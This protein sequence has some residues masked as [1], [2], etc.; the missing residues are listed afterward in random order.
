MS[1]FT[2][3]SADPPSILVCLNLDSS[4]CIPTTENGVFSVNFL[5]CQHTELSDVFS[6]RTSVE[7]EQR[8]E[9]G[10]WEAGATGSPILVDAPAVMECRVTQSYD[11]ATHRVFF[12]EVVAAR[13]TEGEPLVYAMRRYSQ[14]GPLK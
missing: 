8:F 9:F 2:S 10:T 13:T 7:S 11:V 12:A 3:I 5:G 14:L 6:G 1:A 4:G